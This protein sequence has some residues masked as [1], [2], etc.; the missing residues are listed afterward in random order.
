MSDALGGVLGE[1]DRPWNPRD[2]RIKLLVLERE[3]R[4]ELGWDL[5]VDVWWTER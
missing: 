5:E 2:D 4:P 3:L 1:G